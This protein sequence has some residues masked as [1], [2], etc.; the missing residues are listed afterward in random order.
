M[1]FT[2]FTTAEL[3]VDKGIKSTVLVKIRDNLE[4]ARNAFQY[5]MSEL[6]NKGFE[7]QTEGV[8]AL[9]DC[10]TYEDGI[11]QVTS[12]TSY[13][14]HHSLMLIHDGGTRSGGEAISDYFPLTTIMDN[15][16]VSLL[17]NYWGDT[18]VNFNLTMIFYNGSFGVLSSVIT[19]AHA[20]STAPTAYNQ[21]SFLKPANTRWAKL[22]IKTSTAAAATVA[23]TVY[24]DNLSVVGE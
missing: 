2:S 18:T 23:G 20:V 14:G 17:S 19:T 9:W 10:T 5:N 11:I 21:T 15:G 6:P 13:E 16:S 7:Y 1:A 22:K 24:F 4:W 8:P 3:S 12:S